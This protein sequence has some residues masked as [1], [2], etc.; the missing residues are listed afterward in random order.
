MFGWNIILYEYIL[1]SIYQFSALTF[2]AKLSPF[3]AAQ[4]WQ[5]L[6]RSPSTWL[7]SMTQGF[8]WPPSLFVMTGGA[9]A[10]FP[11]NTNWCQ[12]NW[13]SDVKVTLKVTWITMFIYSGLG[14]NGQ[15]EPMYLAICYGKY[16]SSMCDCD[17]FRFNLRLLN[18]DVII[19]LSRCGCY[20]PYV[21]SNYSRSFIQEGFGLIT[22]INIDLHTSSFRW[23]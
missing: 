10:S 20:T 11:L 21:L 8:F 13:H 15:T 22:H 18:I 1:S 6:L 7:A 9:W 2:L 12:P 16:F 5:Y 14:M 23:S 3:L 17:R 19:L 4:G